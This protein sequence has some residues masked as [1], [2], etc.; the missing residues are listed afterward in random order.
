MGGH[1]EWVDEVVARHD[2]GKPFAPENG[3]AL[4]FSVGDVVTY[5]NDFGVTF[6]RTITGLYRPEPPSSL[7][8]RGYRYLVDSDSP[9]MPVREAALHFSEADQ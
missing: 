7:Y 1:H 8:A 4:K 6:R 9:W 5:E 3:Q 2:L